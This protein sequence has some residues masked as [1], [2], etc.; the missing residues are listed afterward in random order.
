MSDNAPSRR[1]LRAC[2]RRGFSLIELMIATVILGIGLVMV[3]TIFPVAVSQTRDAVQKS[4]VQSVADTAIQ[5]LRVKLRTSHAIN[6]STGNLIPGSTNLPGDRPYY[7][8]GGG[9]GNIRSNGLTDLT[10]ITEPT[11]PSSYDT[12][13]TMIGLE[14]LESPHTRGFRVIR[15]VNMAN[16]PDPDDKDGTVKFVRRGG[17]LFD[18]PFEAIL[19]P[20]IPNQFNGG[21]AAGQ[22][23]GDN[24]DNNTPYW[25]TGPPSIPP[26][27]GTTPKIDVLDLVYPPIEPRWVE[28]P[29]NNSPGNGFPRYQDLVRAAGRRYCWIALGAPTTGAAGNGALPYQVRLFVMFRSELTARYPEQTFVAGFVLRHIQPSPLPTNDDT[30][31][32]Q[33]WLVK[34][35]DMAL[36]TGFHTNYTAESVSM[37]AVMG[38]TALLP[39]G[40]IICTK[41]VGDLLP[42]GSIFVDFE[43]GR[44][45]TVLRNMAEPTNPDDLR[46][47]IV[48]P[49]SELNALNAPGGSPVDG[50]K[51]HYP[52]FPDYAW[53]IPPPIVRTGGGRLDF[54]FEGASPVVAVVSATLPRG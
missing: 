53:V 7:S 6:P 3:A 31:F 54:Y 15:Y 4:V 41:E 8:D 44:A 20:H 33:P 16:P 45:H 27:I 25:W 11:G 51:V 23:Y 32:P 29:L 24:S 49:D 36:A 17:I 38:G 35:D 14:T 1:P 46:R 21:T 10:T 18:S 43:L 40:T 52:D 47:L 48:A 22:A 26:R 30:L 2:T 28:E 9:F 19:E 50:M 42:A 12:N 39:P 13:P 37:D 34:F 5:T